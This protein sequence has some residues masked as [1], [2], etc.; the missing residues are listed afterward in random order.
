MNIAL[1]LLIEVV[2]FAAAAYV[3]IGWGGRSS[4]RSPQ[5]VRMNAAHASG[6][7]GSCDSVRGAVLSGTFSSVTGQHYAADSGVNDP[8]G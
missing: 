6:T 2:A 1:G 3:V 8:D 7:S 4:S 5:P